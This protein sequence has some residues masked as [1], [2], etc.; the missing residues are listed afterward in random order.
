M[1]IIRPIA[2]KDA[3]TFVDIAFQAGIGMTSMPKNRDILL[4]RVAESEAAFAKQVKEPDNESYLFVLED[5]KTGKL[6]GTCGIVAKTGINAPL[7]FYHLESLANKTSII[8]NPSPIPIMRVV[9]YYDF[10]TEICSLY[11]LSDFRHSGLG[12]LLS[13]SRFLF[14]AAFT[15]RFD[16]MVFAEMRGFVNSDNTSPFW[17]GIGRHFLDMEYESIMHLRDEENLDIESFMPRYP[18]YIHLLSQEVRESIGRIHNNTQPALSMLAQE[19]FRLSGEIDVFDGGPKIEAETKEIRTIKHSNVA[20]VDEITN[21]EIEGPRYI[22]SNDN[23]NFRAC[24][25]S[26]KRN[27]T[28]GVTLPAETAKALQLKKGSMVRFILPITDSGEHKP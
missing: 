13:L 17:E 19:G 16:K 11:L 4:Q 21:Q 22:L 9:H 18:I 27:G 3:E 6:G 12:K 7:F 5:V 8:P 25:S 1:Y 26:L 10:P 24:Y 23:L 2:Q 20:K 14:I 28:K 15:E